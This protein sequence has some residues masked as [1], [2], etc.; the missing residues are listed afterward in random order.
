MARG[1]PKRAVVASKRRSI[2]WRSTYASPTH[3][4]FS[5]WENYCNGIAMSLIPYRA[6]SCYMLLERT[7]A[8]EFNL[9]R[10]LFPLN[11]R[12]IQ[13]TTISTDINPYCHSSVHAIL[14]FLLLCTWLAI[15]WINK[16]QPTGDHLG[17]S[18][19]FC[20]FKCS[21]LV[22]KTNNYSFLYTSL[23]LINLFILFLIQFSSAHLNCFWVAAVKAKKNFFFR[24]C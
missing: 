9:S 10:H 15:C 14:L 23:F 2:N 5:R 17:R 11:H 16:F 4:G 8:N 24:L 22:A 19:Y 3:W 7:N 18:I 21:S 12:L 20:N 13:P 6:R 1:V